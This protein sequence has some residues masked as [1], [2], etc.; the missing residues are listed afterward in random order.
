MQPAWIRNAGIVQLANEQCGETVG[1]AEGVSL[2]NNDPGEPERL[3]A[4]FRAARPVCNLKDVL[5]PAAEAAGHYGP[6]AAVGA[7][8]GDGRRRVVVNLRACDLRALE[9]LD[10][11]LLSGACR[12]SV[13]SQRRER[14]TVISSDCVECSPACFC[15]LLGNHPYATGGFDL[16]LTPL[17]DGFV[18]EA[19][20]ERGERILGATGGEAATP[21]KLDAR[22]RLRQEM[23]ER[24]RT[25][26]DG[27]A[28]SLGNGFQAALPE[29]NDCAWDAL[30]DRCVECA[31]C[32]NICPSCHC[33]YLYDQILRPDHFERVRTWDSCL[34][35]TYH[36]M[37]GGPNVK[38]SPRPSLGRRL[39]N[40]VLHKFA[41]SPQQYDMIGCVGCGR[42]TEACLGGIDIRDILEELLR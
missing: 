28:L 38:G 21:E 1:S 8:D 13:Y 17:E 20:S 16:N 35:G 4:D 39:A 2:R 7:E 27:F 6:A 5:L 15:T 42:C 25:E 36:R 37:A 24:V 26:N 31:A 29:A 3:S 32:T 34:L 19:G 10:R 22:E 9:Y 41:Y 40:R 33:F 30:A 18:V 14:I 12:D 23:T 11:V